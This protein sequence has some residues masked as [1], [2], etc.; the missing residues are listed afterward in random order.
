VLG[1]LLAGLFVVGF[2]TFAAAER[3][4]GKTVVVALQ[5]WAEENADRLRISQR[6][7]L[8]QTL[9][10]SDGYLSDET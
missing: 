4:V 3:S 1:T 5:S 6:I 9:N 7:P 10:A 2:V 8:D